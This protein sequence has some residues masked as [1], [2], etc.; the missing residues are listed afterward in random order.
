MEM[1]MYVPMKKKNKM[2]MKLKIIFLK[3]SKI[4]LLVYMKMQRSKLKN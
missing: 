1:K 4:D 3:S 2:Q